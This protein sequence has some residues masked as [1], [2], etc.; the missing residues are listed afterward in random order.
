[1][2]GSISRLLVYVHDKILAMPS[3]KKSFP[4]LHLFQGGMSDSELV[5]G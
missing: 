5:T 4:D 2:S 3:L 1:M